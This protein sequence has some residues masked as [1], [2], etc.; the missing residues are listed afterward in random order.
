MQGTFH[1]NHNTHLPCHLLACGHLMMHS[2]FVLT[3]RA[4]IV[5]KSQNSQTIHKSKFPSRIQGY[6]LAANACKIKTVAAYFDIQ[7]YRAFPFPKGET[8]YNKEISAKAWV[9]SKRVN[10]KRYGSMP[11]TRA[12]DEIVWSGSHIA[13]LLQLAPCS[14]YSPS[15]KPPTP[16]VYSFPWQIPHHSGI[17]NIMGSPLHLKLH[18][19]SFT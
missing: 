17:F 1:S 13:S 14:T 10:T 5:F 7:C 4:P 12:C 3:S 19:P 18:L 8:G 9:K 15:L 16:C 11:I 2:A 6:L